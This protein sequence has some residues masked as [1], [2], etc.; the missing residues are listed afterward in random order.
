M[1]KLFIGLC[2]LALPVTGRAMQGPQATTAPTLEFIK[3]INRGEPIRSYQSKDEAGRVTDYRVTDYSDGSIKIDNYL[4][5]GH[6]FYL[7]SDFERHLERDAKGTPVRSSQD[8]TPCDYRSDKLNQ[9]VKHNDGTLEHCYSY[10]AY[11]GLDEVEYHTGLSIFYPAD[12]LLVRFKPQHY[13]GAF[14]IETLVG[15]PSINIVF[16]VYKAILKGN[17]QEVA[18]LLATPEARRLPFSHV[19]LITALEK[20]LQ[21][22]TDE[23]RK[24]IQA[25]T[26]LLLQAGADIS[27]RDAQGRS[28]LT[29]VGEH[30]VLASLLTSIDPAQR[31]NALYI[32]I[33]AAD[34]QLMARVLQ[35]QDVAQRQKLVNAPLATGNT[36][37]AAALHITSFREPYQQ[38][39]M[40]TI[41]KQLMAAGAKPTKEDI[42]Y[43]L[44]GGPE[45]L[46]IFVQASGRGVFDAIDSTDR[47]QLDKLLA[48]MQKKG[49][50]QVINTMTNDAGQTPLVYALILALG[51]PAGTDSFHRLLYSAQ[52]LINQGATLNNPAGNRFIGQHGQE[53]R[54]KLSPYIKSLQI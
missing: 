37:L 11:T 1:N 25:I 35:A 53:A 45:L 22:P 38:E 20:F 33:K 4:N 13:Q 36:P 43:A 32:A 16:A 51:V 8:R 52:S 15:N 27:E 29:L 9:L 14:R 50:I 24:N 31:E 19:L 18:K 17:S 54:K 46:K 48:E 42:D 41:I 2:I 12:N 47:A 6:T 44:S 30:P 39:N 23:Q 7:S 10:Q 34:S 26:T 49:N 3:S 40:P 21:A 28:V 5:K